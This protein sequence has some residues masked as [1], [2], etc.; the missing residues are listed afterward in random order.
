MQNMPLAVLL[1][2]SLQWVTA[3]PHLSGSVFVDKERGYIACDFKLSGL[4]ALRAYRILLNHGMNIKYFKDTR[5]SLMVY[6]GYYEGEMKGEALAYVLKS[7]EG[8]TLSLPEAFQVAYTGAFP[9]YKNAYNSFDYKGYIA[10]NETTFRA[11][12]QSKWY[13]VIYDVDQDRLIDSYTYDITVSHP[14]TT[15]VFL[16]GSAP[17]QEEPALLQSEKA[18]PPFL[19]AGDYDFLAVDEDFLLNVEISMETARAIFENTGKI[20]TSLAGLM[21]SEFTDHLYFVNFESVRKFGPN[22]NWG[23]NIYPAIA[24]AGLDF[25]N[26]MD[27]TG[28]FWSPIL[29]FLAHEMAH[30]YFGPNVMSGKYFWFW[31]ESVPEYLSLLVAEELRG[32]GV[33]EYEMTQ[34]KDAVKNKAFI[35]LMAVQQPTDI[36]QDY[37]YRLGPLILKVFEGTFGRDKTLQVLGELRARSGA[38]PLNPTVWKEVSLQSGI[39]R[40]AWDRFSLTYLENPDFAKKTIEWIEENEL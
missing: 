20:K 29:N 3:Q 7:G 12:E 4:P 17:T 33:V 32:R 18:V 24:Y 30:N 38:G 35:P 25:G 1:L 13:P 15:T 6:D 23:F 22:E 16:N 19:F 31:L 10:V 40:A 9:V 21:K 26:M 28:Q 2:F 39:S 37:R 5:D 27:E 11:T 8:D 34:M 14:H 36:G